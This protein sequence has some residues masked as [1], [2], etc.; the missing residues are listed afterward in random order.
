MIVEKTLYAV[1]LKRK[2]LQPRIRSRVV[3][4]FLTRREKRVLMSQRLP[5]ER[6]LR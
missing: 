6:N 5:I 3:I 1:F 4:S 2:S